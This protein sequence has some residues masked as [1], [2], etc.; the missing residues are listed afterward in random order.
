M[1]QFMMATEQ[2]Q[3]DGMSMSYLDISSQEDPMD[4]DCRSSYSGSINNN[5]TKMNITV[6]TPSPSDARL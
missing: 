1:R 6:V 2:G 4:D 5:E 3:T